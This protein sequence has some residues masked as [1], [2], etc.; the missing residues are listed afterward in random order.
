MLGEQQEGQLTRPV[1]G[2]IERSYGFD[3]GAFR[4]VRLEIRRDPITGGQ[5]ATHELE[6]YGPHREHYTFFAHYRDQSL[7]VL[8]GFTVDSPKDLEE[9]DSR[10]WKPGDRL[11]IR[12]QLRVPA[13]TYHVN[14]GF[15]VLGTNRRMPLPKCPND[16]L[17]L[18]A[19]TIDFD[20]VDQLQRSGDLLP[21]H[22]S[23]LLEEVLAIP[24]SPGIARD[25]LTLC[26]GQA[27]QFGH[28][29]EFGVAS[30]NT[31]NHLAA[32]APHRCIWGFDTFDGLP[33]PWVKSDNRIV[34][35]GTFSL[36]GKLPEVR[37]N[38]R[39]VRGLIQETL[40]LW[41]RENPGNISFIHIDADLYSAAKAI[42]E[43]LD[44]RIVPSTVIVFDDVANWQALQQ[45]QAGG[46]DHWRKGEWRAL[47]E[48]TQNR[49]RRFAVISRLR[50]SVLGIRVLS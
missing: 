20:A 31:I 19:V 45:G 11:T 49:R 29:L 38:V 34:P 48:W 23:S 47:L 1:A 4:Y 15:Y 17:S 43:L 8:R 50:N 44:E 7:P 5:L 3:T 18:G 21:A 22:P 32:L 6:T 12:R 27:P 9:P 16:V 41:L 36:H 25:H 40:P 24:A 46:Y 35:A 42:L 13:A 10:V 26:F 37:D 2:V 39:L 33:E 14:I 30:G 28:V